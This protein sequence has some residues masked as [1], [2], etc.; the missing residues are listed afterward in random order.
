MFRTA[1]G[2]SLSCT[3]AEATT[4]SFYSN[5]RSANLNAD[6]HTL[7][8]RYYGHFL[9]SKKIGLVAFHQQLPVEARIHPV[10]HVSQLILGRGDKPIE[11]ELPTEIARA[12]H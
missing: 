2:G 7:G 12:G 10:F 4:T 11:A 1:V 3:N 9:V 6:A 8:S 5:V